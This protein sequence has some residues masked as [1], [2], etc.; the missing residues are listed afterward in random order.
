MLHVSNEDLPLSK[1]N[2]RIIILFLRSDQLIAYVSLQIARLAEEQAEAAAAE[3]VADA[4]ADTS[5]A[6]PVSSCTTSLRH[7]CII[8]HAEPVLMTMVPTCCI[9]SSRSL[10]CLSSLFAPSSPSPSYFPLLMIICPI[11]R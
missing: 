10:S 1:R 6:K 5:P 2:K 4:A 7:T 11:E 8:R 9:W 3:A